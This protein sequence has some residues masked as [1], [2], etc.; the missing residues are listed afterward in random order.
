[1]QVEGAPALPHSLPGA[2]LLPLVTVLAPAKIQ[3]VQGDWGTAPEMRIRST[4]DAKGKMWHLGTQLGG[5][6]GNR[7]AIGLKSNDLSLFQP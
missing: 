6:G 5:H 2:P 3:V 4:S 1:M 7:L